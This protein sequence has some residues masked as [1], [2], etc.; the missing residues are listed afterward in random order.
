MPLQY[1]AKSVFIVVNASLRWLNNV[2]GAY[3]VQVSLLLI[4][5]GDLGHFYRYRPCFPWLEDCA[6][7]SPTLEFSVNH[8]SAIQAASQSIFSM[9]NYTTGMKKISS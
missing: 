4:G 3:L 1:N 8:F 2:S 9:N 5:Q 6:D 7:F